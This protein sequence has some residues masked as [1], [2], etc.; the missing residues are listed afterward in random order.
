M[1][2]LVGLHRGGFMSAHVVPDRD[3]TAPAAWTEHGKRPREA[4][5]TASG[6]VRRLDGGVPQTPEGE[7]P[8]IADAECT[9]G[10][11]PEMTG[12]D[13]SMATR[14]VVE[15]FFQRLAAGEPDDFTALLA[16]EVDWLI[17]GDAG[18]APWVGRRSTRSGVAEYLRLLR[19]NVE[20]L[21]AE[22]QHVL[23]DSD[24]AI[25]VG[26]FASR[27]HKTGKVVESIFFAQFLVRDG[28]VVRYRLLEDTQAVVAALTP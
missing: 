20:P 24:M 1:D 19:A 15:T 25:A 14:T 17:P 22:V 16:D 27:M 23:V 3:S 13:S 2:A 21:R 11:E 4:L 12:A 9:T 5:A 7:R 10:K 28:L 8:P 18:V 26:E 6:A